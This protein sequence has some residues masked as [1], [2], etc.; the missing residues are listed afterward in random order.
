MFGDCFISKGNESGDVS[1]RESLGRRNPNKWQ[2]FWENR[3]KDNLPKYLTDMFDSGDPEGELS[4]AAWQTK[5]V[6]EMFTKNAKTQKWEVDLKKP[7]FQECKNRFPIW[8]SWKPLDFVLIY[9]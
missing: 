1:A 6:N 2:K 3:K 4:N 9:F 8:S 7:M 5:V